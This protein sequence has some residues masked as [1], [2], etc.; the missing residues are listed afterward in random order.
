MKNKVIL[1]RLPQGVHPPDGYERVPSP[2][3]TRSV[4]SGKTVV[5]QKII[6]VTE[7]KDIDE[8]ADLF[9]HVKMGAPIQVEVASTQDELSSLLSKFHFGGGNKNKKSKKRTR[10]YR[11]Y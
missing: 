8:L 7:K 10:K 5:W 3:K 4:T 2:R 9:G 6:D 1:L 11:K